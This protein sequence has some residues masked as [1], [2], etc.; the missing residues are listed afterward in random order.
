LSYFRRHSIFGLEF[1]DE[2]SY[3]RYLFD[4]NGKVGTVNVK[5]SKKKRSLIC[6]F[7]NVEI[8]LIRP[9]VQK[10]RRMFDAD[11]NPLLLPVGASEEDRSIR[12]PT[13]FDPFEGAVMVLLGQLVSTKQAQ[14]RMQKLVQNCGD[15]L[16]DCVWQFP[17][18]SQLAEAKL[19]GLTKT[20]EQAIKTF[21]RMC[22]ERVLHFDQ[23][24]E[25]F[26]S[27]A[28][29]IKGVGPW[30]QNIIAMNCL[31]DCDRFVGTDLIVAKSK[32]E[33]NEDHWKPV[34]SYF[35]HLIWR[36]HVSKM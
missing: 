23:D 32:L 4:S 27:I 29:Q 1:C 13:P 5:F 33:K 28:S 21:S 7:S 36:Q 6:A 9:T 19:I 12:C 18:P 20:L 15:Q 31:Y 35:S 17:S 8:S 22:A 25:I 24:P 30:S 14:L 11:W 34:R 26:M 3:T 2:K 16:T 10:I